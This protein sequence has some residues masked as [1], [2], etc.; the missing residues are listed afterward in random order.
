MKE[1]LVCLEVIELAE[2]LLFI[3]L[4]GYGLGGR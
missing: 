1:E 3:S 2:D 4:P